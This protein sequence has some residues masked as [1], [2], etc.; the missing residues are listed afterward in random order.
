MKLQN[1]ITVFTKDTQQRARMQNTDGADKAE[2][3]G[4]NEKNKTFYAGNFLVEFPLKDRIEQRKAQAQ[5]RAMKIVNDAWEGDRKLDR[6]IEERRERIQELKEENQEMLEIFGPE[7]AGVF[8]GPNLKAIA[9][10]SQIISG[11]K[12]ERLKYHNMV[13]AQEQAEDVVESSRDD[14]IGMVMEEA[15]DHVDEEQKKREEQA[16]AIQEKKEEQEEILEK[17]E[18]KE[19]ELEKLMEE[20]PTEQS[21]DNIDQTM[22]EVKRQVQKVLNEVNLMEEDIKGSRVDIEV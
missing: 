8:I 5:E 10:E 21:V 4:Q 15:K 19:E 22:A 6:E 11:I 7:D 20:M 12:K 16:E 2:K 14:I 3:G 17:R 1:N 9:E 18:E 13:D